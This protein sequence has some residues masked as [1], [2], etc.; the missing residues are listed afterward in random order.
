MKPR[1]PAE[2]AEEPSDADLVTRAQ[3]G[4]SGAFESLVKRHLR[5]AHAVAFAVLTEQADADDAVQDGFLSALQ[6]LDSCSPP[7]KFRAWLLTIVRNRAFDMRRRGRVRAVEVLEDETAHAQDA[8]PLEA[9]ERSELNARLSAA[10]ETLTDSQREVLMMHDIEGWKHADIAHLL[11]L[12]ESTVRVH[13]LHARR[14]L[15]TVLL[16]VAPESR[17]GEAMR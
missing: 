3:G 17:H 4:E 11:G 5:A 7:E 6:H 14:R 13:L 16:A 9:A 12:A 8:S 15:R 2:Q 10:I 1:A